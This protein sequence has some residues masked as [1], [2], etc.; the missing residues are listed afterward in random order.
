MLSILRSSVRPIST[1]CWFNYNAKSIIECAAW[2]K[3]ALPIALQLK[4][5]CEEQNPQENVLILY[6]EGWL[7]VNFEKYKTWHKIYLLYRLFGKIENLLHLESD[8]A[9][10]C[11]ACS[12][13]LWVPRNFRFYY[14]NIF[15]A[16]NSVMTWI[17]TAEPQARIQY[18]TV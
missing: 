13:W 17:L 9:E 3:I 7:S 12:Y 5:F 18:Q 10:P 11:A 8:L 6:F 2:L 1:F 4:Q 14:E 15:C 16:S